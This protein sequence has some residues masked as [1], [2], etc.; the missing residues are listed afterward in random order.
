MNEHLSNIQVLKKR[1]STYLSLTI[2][3]QLIKHLGRKVKHLIL[4]EIKEATYFP[5]LIDS[6]PDVSHGDQRAF[7]IRYVKVEEREA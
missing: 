3:N 1:M 4:K 7:V 5:V 6:N 2:Q